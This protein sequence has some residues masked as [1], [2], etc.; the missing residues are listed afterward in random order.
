MVMDVHPISIKNEN[1][2]LKK[3]RLATIDLSLL[4]LKRASETQNHQ[5]TKAQ[6]SGRHQFLKK[7]TGKRSTLDAFLK[8]ARY[9]YCSWYYGMYFPYQ[10]D[11]HKLT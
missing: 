9:R 4:H 6:A 2:L 1:G 5:S 11:G 10:P 3:G 7:C 8:G